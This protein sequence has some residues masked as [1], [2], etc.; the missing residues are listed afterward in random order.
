MLNHIVTETFE[1]DA[2][3]R[4]SSLCRC[5]LFAFLAPLRLCANLPTAPS[6]L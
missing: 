1:S 2:Q 6:N 3:S 5:V 4:F